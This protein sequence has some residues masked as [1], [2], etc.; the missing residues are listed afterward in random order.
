MQVQLR[1]ENM[2]KSCFRE[3][4]QSYL[5]ALVL[6]DTERQGK[7]REVLTLQFHI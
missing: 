7:T 3:Y 5:T 2:N 6:E 4:C 1:L